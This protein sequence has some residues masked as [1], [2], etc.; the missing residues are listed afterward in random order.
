VSVPAQ[1]WHYRAVTDGTT[2]VG[3]LLNRGPRGFEAFTGA[4]ASLGLFPNQR[5][6]ITAIPL[7]PGRGECVMTRRDFSKAAARDRMRRRGTESVSGSTTPAAGTPS[8]R[9]RNSAPAPAPEPIEIGRFIKNRKGDFVVVQIK[10]FEGF[11][12]LDVRQFFTGE[13]G[14]SRPTK[15]GIAVGLGKIEELARLVD[16]ARKTAIERGLL[17][18]QGGE[19]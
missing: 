2:T 11:T 13:D 19:R 5:A 6:A 14:K 8:G 16:K 7:N 3:F 4:G 9:E 18:A 1:I 15:K 17:R 10:Q 12:F